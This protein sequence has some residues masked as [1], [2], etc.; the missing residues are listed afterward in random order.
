MAFQID[1][2]L[3]EP[4]DYNVQYLGFR[5][6]FSFGTAEDSMNDDTVD[7]VSDNLAN[8]LNTEPG[9]RL[10]HPK[11]GV[12]FRK[13]LFNQMDNDIEEFV[14]QLTSDQFEKITNFF[15]TM[16]KLSHKVSVVNP[17]TKV[18]GEVVLEGLQSFLG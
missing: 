2:N 15:Q 7:N 10:F 6:P 3:Y 5:L 11:L 9:D 14:D 1:S 8:L 16:P 17:K 4:A 13:H 12:N 18:Q